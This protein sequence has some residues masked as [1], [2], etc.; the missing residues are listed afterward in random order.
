MEMASLH[1]NGNGQPFV[2]MEMGC[3]MGWKAGH[4]EG[5]WDHPMNGNHPDLL[6]FIFRE[7]LKSPI[8]PLPGS[9]GMVT[10]RNLPGLDSIVGDNTPEVPEGAWLSDLFVPWR[11]LLLKKSGI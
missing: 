8:Y 7:Q 6:N 9:L 2:G 3:P 11:D 4:R 1:P 10:N 5:K